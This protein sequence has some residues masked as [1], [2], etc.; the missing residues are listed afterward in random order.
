MAI[1]NICYNKNM[2][3]IAISGNIA[4]GKSAVEKILTDI[5]YPIIDTDKIVHE[6][7]EKSETFCS[8]INSNFGMYDIFSDG[9]IDKKKLAKIV[10]SDKKLLKKLEFIIHPIVEDKIKTFFDKNR[11]NKLVFTAIPLLYEANFTH[12]FDKVIFIAADDSIRLQRLVTKR[13]FSKE[14]A[15]KR[16]TAQ[17]PQEEKIKLADYTIQNNSTLDDLK[18]QIKI[19]LDKLI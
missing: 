1:K 3:K 4:S 10:F 8:Q 9:K 11:N 7:Y 14:D 17:M 18:L 15:I 16:M 19:I 13:N 12:L 2:I 6:L 5:G